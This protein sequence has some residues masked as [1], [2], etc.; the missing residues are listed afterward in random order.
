MLSSGKVS[1]LPV[2]SGYELA[3]RS[4]AVSLNLDKFQGQ[5]AVKLYEPGRHQSDD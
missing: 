1:L 4:D 5:A 3:N 2:S